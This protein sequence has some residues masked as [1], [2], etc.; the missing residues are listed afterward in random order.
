M[1]EIDNFFN[2]LKLNKIEFFSGVPDSILK[3]TKHMLSKK[4]FKSHLVAANEGIAASICIGNYLATG[5]VPCLYLQNSGLGNAINPLSSISHKNVYSIPILLL[6]GW[7]GAPGEKDEPQH[8][9]KGRITTTLLKSLNIKYCHLNT[10]KDFLR[11]KKLISYGKKFK[12]PVACLIKKNT[13]KS[14]KKIF[15]K[16]DRKGINREFF[17]R[18]LLKMITKSSKIVSTTGYTSRELYQ[19]R[20]DNDFKL[21]KDFYMVGGM[22]HA[23][24]VALGLSLKSKS[25]VICLDGD[26]SF[27]MHLG[28]STN[29]GKFG[30]KN[31]KHVLLNN[32]CHESVGGQST[33]IDN[34]NIKQAVKSFG[35]KKYFKIYNIN[36]MSIVKKFLSSNGPSFLEVIIKTGSMKNLLRP[37]N[38]RNIAKKFMKK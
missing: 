20:L 34:I 6:I 27:L 23:T 9:V 32:F 2:F 10:E 17:L 33:N 24:G 30:Q 21:G 3:E 19:I 16:I 26:G 11:L 8:M 5:K 31:F 12:A 18:G 28:S 13:F 15:N 4:N 37:K 36:Q 35:Y 7:R 38:L 22:G 1:I 29:I 25:N 14:N